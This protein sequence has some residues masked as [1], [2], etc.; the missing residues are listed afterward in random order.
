[1]DP[2]SAATLPRKSVPRKMAAW[3]LLGFS[4]VETFL[5]IQI[6]LIK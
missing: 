6:Y 4:L 2:V 3:P 1:M 5:L